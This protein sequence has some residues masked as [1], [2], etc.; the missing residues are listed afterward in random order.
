MLLF[1]HSFLG[2]TAHDYARS[3][4]ITHQWQ[5]T[6]GMAMLPHVR[7]VASHQRLKHIGASQ[8]VSRNWNLDEK[9]L[10]WKMG[11]KQTSQPSTKGVLDLC[12]ARPF[13]VSTKCILD[14]IRTCGNL[15]QCCHDATMPAGWWWFI[16][17]RAMTAHCT[18]VW[19]GCDSTYPKFSPR[20]S[21]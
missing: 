13:A 5:P 12:T 4:K 18:A 7:R 2:V 21:W 15:G 20:E 6:N 1:S 8:P 9:V 3:N 10:L 19:P 14:H 16:L 11:G 17:C